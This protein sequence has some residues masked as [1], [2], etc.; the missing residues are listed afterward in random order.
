M[1]IS[2]EMIGDRSKAFPNLKFKIC[3]IKNFDKRQHLENLSQKDSAASA[4]KSLLY[5]STT[6]LLL[7]AGDS[8]STI[9]L[10]SN[11]DIDCAHRE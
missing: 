10:I 6:V 2:I 9:L 4:C 11:S 8:P 7:S 3:P 1:L 5:P